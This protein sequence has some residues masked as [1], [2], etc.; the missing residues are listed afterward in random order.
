MRRRDWLRSV[1]GWDGCL[2]LV[3]AAA[4]I[5]LPAILPRRDL[6]ELTAVILLPIIAALLR[7]HQG[8]RQL[9]RCGNRATL[10][11]QFLFGG[12]VAMLLLFEGFAGVLHCA[13]GVPPSAWLVAGAIYLAYLCLIVPALRPRRLADA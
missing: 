1:I 13:Q 4:P 5:L 12:A 10:G 8:R 11:R 2:P 7:A 3:V 6:A 9:E